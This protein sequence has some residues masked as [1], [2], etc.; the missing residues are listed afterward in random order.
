MREKPENAA[1]KSLTLKEFTGLMFEKVRPPLLC[2]PGFML[3]WPV[4]PP[5]IQL[6][7]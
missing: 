4:L 1:L 2:R 6:L 5:A 3:A 7:E